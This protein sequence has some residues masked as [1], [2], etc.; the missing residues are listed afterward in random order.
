MEKREAPIIGISTE[1]DTP[2]KTAVKSR[3]VDAIIQAGG[4][5][6]LLP[7]TDNR[8]VLQAALALVDGLLL[9]GGCDLSPSLYGQPP[10]AE[11]GA[12]CRE[13]DSYDYT[14]LRLAHERQIPVFGICRGMQVINTFFGGTMYQDLP[15]QCPSDVCHRSPDG[16]L[17]AQ[18]TIHCCPDSRL[19]RI[20]GKEDLW[21]SSIHHQAIKE[22]AVGFRATAFAPD[23]IIE[24]IEST[25]VPNIWGVQFHPEVQGTTDDA[26]MHQLFSSFIT[27]AKG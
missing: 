12:V 26:E 17:V 10:L 1:V 14:L 21:I 4:I 27:Q 18:H 6:Y 19:L 20:T 11:C 5:P 7:F 25:L 23:G 3:Y 13:R 9:T 2:E 16:S 15:S 22:I 8:V 24:A